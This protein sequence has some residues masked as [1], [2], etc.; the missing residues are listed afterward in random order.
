MKQLCAKFRRNST[1]I[2][3]SKSTEGEIISG[4]APTIPPEATTP[5]STSLHCVMG[6]LHPQY[7]FVTL[8]N[9][10]RTCGLRRKNLKIKAHCLS[11]GINIDLPEI[12]AI[13]VWLT[14]ICVL[15]CSRAFLITEVESCVSLLF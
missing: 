3:P 4:G 14:F 7:S 9:L 15:I 13:G 8:K 2:R 10:E 12:A 1:K 6:R 11:K 5:P